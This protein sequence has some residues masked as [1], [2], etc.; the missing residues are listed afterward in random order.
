MEAL[1]TSNY[2]MIVFGAAAPS[3]RCNDT[4][5]SVLNTSDC[6]LDN[7]NNVVFS[8]QLSSVATE[9]NAR[10]IVRHRHS[11]LQFGLYCDK[12]WVPDM[13]PSIQGAGCLVGALIWGQL[14]EMFG[15]KWVS[16]GNDLSKDVQKHRYL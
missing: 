13:L 10:R 6:A 1:L 5:N 3:W 7:C 14:S 16:V 12:A 11:V 15:R 8:E 4:S 9:V 2:L